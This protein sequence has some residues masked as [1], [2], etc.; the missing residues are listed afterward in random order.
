MLTNVFLD[1]LPQLAQSDVGIG[2]RNLSPKNVVVAQSARVAIGHRIF[3]GSERKRSFS[4]PFLTSDIEG[5][6]WSTKKTGSK[7]ADLV[8]STVELLIFGNAGTV[9][10]TI[11]QALPV[12]VGPLRNYIELKELRVAH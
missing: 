3:C 7:L 8:H 2:M 5:L 1:V 6:H 11:L 12:Y 10:R 9:W 4:D